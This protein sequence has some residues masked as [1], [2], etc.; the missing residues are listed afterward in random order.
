[1]VAH[2]PCGRTKE[3][4]HGWYVPSSPASRRH[5]GVSPARPG[6]AVGLSAPSLLPHVL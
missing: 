2:F 3:S 1:M 5:E 4:A 6:A